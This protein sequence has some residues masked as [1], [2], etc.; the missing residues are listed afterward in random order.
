MDEKDP[1]AESDSDGAATADDSQFHAS[2]VV[3]DEVTA[4]PREVLSDY[5]VEEEGGFRVEVSGVRTLEHL[6]R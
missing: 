1:K 3:E 2:E 5:W 6:Q 4:P